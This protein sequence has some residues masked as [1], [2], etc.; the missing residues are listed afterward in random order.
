MSLPHSRAIDR[1]R[2]AWR[3]AGLAWS[4]GAG[5]TASAQTPGHSPADRST[6]FLQTATRVVVNCHSDEVPSV[7]DAVG[8][9]FQ[10]LHDEPETRYEYPDDRVAIRR[11]VGNK[12]T[13]RQ[14]NA[15]GKRALYR[16]EFPADAIVYVVEGEEDVHAAE[17]VGAAATC[18]AMGAGK[19]HLADWSP[20]AGH[21][22][23][24][25]R[26]KDE[27]GR[28]HA[29]QV[30]ELL[31]KIN[32]E[33]VIVEAAVGKDLADHIAAGH[34]LGELVPVDNRPRR[35]VITWGDRVPIERVEWWEP[36]WIP[37]A[38]LS[39][40]AGREG[41]GKSTIA[42][43]WAARETRAGNRVAY[44]HSEDSRSHTVA[45]RLTAAGADM[46]KVAFFDVH[47][48]HTT[49]GSLTLPGD[50]RLLEET[51]AA[52][53]I[54][55][56]ILDAVKSFKDPK[57]GQ[58][59]EEIRQL[60][61]PLAQLA[62]RLGIVVIGL[63]HFGKRDGND[64]GKLI[65]GSI[66]WSQVARSVVS[67]AHDDENDR[68]VVTNTKANLAPRV[69]SAA[70]RIVSTR[71]DTA[72]GP[73]E[74][75]VVEWLGDVDVDAR[76]L[77][78]GP[79]DRDVAD[80]LTEGERWLFDY[81]SEHQPAPSAKAKRDGA[82]ALG[83]SEKTIQRAAKKLN[84]TSEAQGFP[85]T[86]H[87]SL[88]DLADGIE[89]QIARWSGDVPTVPTDP[90][91]VPAVPTVPTGSDQHEQNV[92]TEAESQSGQHPCACP[93]CGEPLGKTGRC[94]N[95]IVSRAAAETPPGSLR[96]RGCG[97]PITAPTEAERTASIHDG[98]ADQEAS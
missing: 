40:L 21:A 16:T 30:A 13:F 87:W 33:H 64:T 73:S 25:V 48:E 4:D 88:P 83:V 70:A 22:V 81:L 66:A 6:T 2:D 27:P 63:V 61:E 3:S 9:T 38:A 59:D 7:L 41:L 24:I 60:L 62:G 8:L 32:V 34:D 68:L 20:L 37:K 19:A 28:R 55:M 54:T 43:G 82:K 94:V 90:A 44:L 10:D 98:C 49:T 85:R 50:L 31:D 5:G 89:D 36:E 39:L 92:P 95:C 14:L 47:T 93:D 75:G 35:L 74:V 42:C 53:G 15:Q 56:V 17:A 76:D 57:L 69:R 71:V 77:L 23:V 51:V 80:D 29:D 1:C 58:S 18:S 97:F 96:C 26:D 72:A 67:V 12:K 52:N 11:M 46:S 79:E 65:L 91:R 45:A 78:A 84:V 86:T